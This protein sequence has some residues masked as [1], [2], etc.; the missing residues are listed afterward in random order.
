[1]QSTSTQHLKKYIRGIKIRGI[2]IR[3]IKIRGIKMKIKI[4]IKTKNEN[5]FTSR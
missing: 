3:G 2:K 5:K 1:M 4:E